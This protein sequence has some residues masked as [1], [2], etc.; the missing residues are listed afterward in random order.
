MIVEKIADVGAYFK[1]VGAAILCLGEP[2][3]RMDDE[4]Q[5]SHIKM[6]D[7]NKNPIRTAP[8]VCGI[9]QC[10]HVPYEHDLVEEPGGVYVFVPKTNQ[11]GVA[12]LNKGD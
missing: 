8:G 3:R 5:Y 2:C 4:M 12:H 7:Y 9:R 11:M 10:V 6:P 1:V